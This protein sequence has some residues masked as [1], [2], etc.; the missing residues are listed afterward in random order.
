MIDE[1]DPRWQRMAEKAAGYRIP[2]Y[3]IPGLLRYT[4]NHIKPGDFLC[5]VL[6]ND[7][8]QACERADDVNREILFQYV[9]FL[10]NEAPGG[11]WGSEKNFNAWIGEQE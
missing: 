1:T 4:L 2:D 6:K 9:S 5:A 7:L 8:R 10:Y 11:C 3:M